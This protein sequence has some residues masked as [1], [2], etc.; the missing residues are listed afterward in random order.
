MRELELLSHIQ[1]RSRD[2]AAL[3]PSIEVGPG[4]DCAVLRTGALQSPTGGT[5]RTLLKVD[6][7]VEGRHFLPST[8]LDRV[9]H[10]ALARPLSDI[11]AMGGEPVAALAS[12][13]I[14]ADCTQEKADA[15]FDHAHAAAIRLRCPL[16][17]GD[18]AS[19]QAGTPLSLSVS[20][21]GACDGEP[22]L[23]SGARAG[24]D[25]YVTGTIGG[26][27]GA[28]LADPW[29][30]T[31]ADA[32]GTALAHGPGEKHLWFEPRIAEALW[33]RRVVSQDLHAMMDL[34]DGLGIDAWRLGVASGVVLEIDGALVPLASPSLTTLQA[35]GAGEDYELLFTVRGGASVPDAC[36]AT[37]TRVTRIGR[38]AAASGEGGATLTLTSG[39][40][41]D[42]R[43][44]GFEHGTGP[45]GSIGARA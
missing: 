4:D 12:A 13:L 7:V 41:V 5:R 19:G 18:I 37:G 27:F 35:A 31:H 39:D 34:S 20:I 33:L 8:P 6:Q 9:A 1:R 42:G 11:A 45:R 32:P 10:K 28:G 24:D 17:G 30:G 23:R 14:P 43:T 15:L 21:L 36:P 25:V 29:I 38:V 3:F 16:V 44:L 22:L 40:R 26:S 2:L